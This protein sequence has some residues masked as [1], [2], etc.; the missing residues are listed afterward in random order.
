M[1]TVL[2]LLWAPGSPNNDSYDSPE[3]CVIMTREGMFDDK[4]CN[5][6][7]PFICKILGNETEYNEKCDNYDSGL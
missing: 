6:I 3:H 4:P 7:Y 1:G 5:N 2:D